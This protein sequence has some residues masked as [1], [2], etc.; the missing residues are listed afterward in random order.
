MIN[1]SLDINKF[2]SLKTNESVL[3]LDNNLLI[4]LKELF[5]D[6]NKKKI[7]KNDIGGVHILKNQKLQNKKETMTNKVNLILN[8]LSESH[9]N[10]LLSEFLENINQINND[11]YIEIQKTFYLKMILEPVFMD[12]YLKFFKLVSFIYN[13]V[14]KY[15]ISYFINLVQNKFYYD[16]K[17]IECDDF[18]KKLNNE[19]NRIANLQLIINMVNNNIVSKNIYNECDNIII[20]NKDNIIDI[21]QWFNLRN[22]ILSSDDKNKIKLILNNIPKLSREYILLNSLLENKE[23]NNNTISK[24]TNITTNKNHLSS[25]ECDNIIEEYILIKSIDDI[26]FFIN[27]R[28]VD[29]VNKNIFCENLINKYFNSKKETIKELNNLIKLLIDEQLIFKS[30][31]SKG[32]SMVYNNWDELVIDYNNPTDK[33]MSLLTF[34]KTLNITKNIEYIYND[35]S[36]KLN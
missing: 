11:E 33:M 20:N 3:K 12:I 16:Y 34:Y 18:L 10:N 2:I 22:K 32:L 5:G 36:I 29:A 13:K 26:K 31:L 28:C 14:L 7:N 1:N 4:S 35:F 19:S 25:L 6:L 8:K 15:D 27:N 9:M 30:N 23:I 24:P 21:Y 17:N